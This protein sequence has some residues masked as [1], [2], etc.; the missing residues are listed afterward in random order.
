MNSPEDRQRS[1]GELGGAR[2]TPGG[3]QRS[4]EEPGGAR[5]VMRFPKVNGVIRRRHRKAELAHYYIYA[6]FLN[7]LH[8]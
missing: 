3:A 4:P 6:K 8:V 5:R 2:R 7:Y 1:P